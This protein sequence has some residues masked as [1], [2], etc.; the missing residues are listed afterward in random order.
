MSAIQR[1]SS[2]GRPASAGSPAKATGAPRV[3]S[4][5]QR[6]EAAAGKTA[7]PAPASGSFSCPSCHHIQP[8]VRKYCSKCGAY[9]SNA[10]S[11][12]SRPA[13]AAPRAPLTARAPS[14]AG[15]AAKPGATLQA[16]ARAA[17]AAVEHS[18][19]AAATAAAAAK[20]AA[21][22]ELARTRALIE[23][24]VAPPAAV[25]EILPPLDVQPQKSFLSAAQEAAIAPK[26]TITRVLS[27]PRI[28]S[29]SS[30]PKLPV[31]PAGDV[32]EV[33]VPHPAGSHVPVYVM[34]PLDTVGLDNRLKDPEAIAVK[35]RAL[36]DAGA[37]GVM[38]DVWWGLVEGRHPKAYDF[39]AYLRLLEITA[40]AGLKLQVVT[41]FHKCG[42]NVGDQVTI[43]LPPWVV[44]VGKKNPD[45]FYCDQDGRYNDEYISLGA[46]N[47]PLFPPNNR[48]AIQ[49]YADFLAAFAD[50][51][52]AYFG[53]IL[54]QVQVS[55]G[56]AGE[57]RY[58][59]Y[60]LSMGWRFPGIGQFQCYD[61]Y[62]LAQLKAAAEAHGRPEWGAPFPGKAVG[63]YNSKPQETA[64]FA[65][66]GGLWATDHGHFFLSWY[67]KALIAHG[68]RVLAVAHKI[69]RP[70]GINARRS[71]SLAAKV[72]GI[73]WWYRTNA[74]AAELTAGYYNTNG[75]D[76]YLPIARMM[77]L[78]DAHFD[79]TCLEMR[80][81]ESN[82]EWACSPEDLVLQ[83]GR[84]AAAAGV[85]F[86][87]ENALP[88][89]D[90][91]AY[92]QMV[93][94][95]SRTRC[96]ALTYLRLSPD[97]VQKENLARFARFCRV[98]RSVAAPPRP[99]RGR[100]ANTD[101]LELLL[102]EWFHDDA[103]SKAHVP[104]DGADACGKGLPACPC[105]ACADARRLAEEQ[106]APPKPSPIEGLYS[107]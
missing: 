17:V 50:T 8:A 90:D 99:S 44:E 53:T 20:A 40:Q 25:T 24:A 83:V 72:A 80:N 18:A 51:M 59:S 65:D 6:Y 35:L 15:A 61:K 96:T 46:D 1:T 58:P 70:A 21:E 67:S 98:M 54:T 100:P 29:G 105:D 76:G 71:V 31:A 85:E 33:E 86:A 75:R 47:E 30:T 107:A 37:E 28:A 39:S 5:L 13:S 55:L 41:S 14:Q 94:A 26:S 22:E 12:A 74:H 66:R 89:H 63:G 9:F 92:R 84:A 73:H 93:Y 88:R 103:R 38:V 36:K 69:L 60:P 101:F 27:S 16:K 49:C 23:A 106:K 104:K 64:F 52:R 7:A 81:C 34:M 4:L 95:C 102:L 3:A 11:A 77:A 43:P 97:L 45:I 87:G 91:Y 56:P 42:G 68:E 48:T 32:T 2:G 78:F 62:M 19:S 79:F 10:N 82:H 57:L